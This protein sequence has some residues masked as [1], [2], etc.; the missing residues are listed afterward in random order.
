M[1]HTN[2]SAVIAGLVFIALSVVFLLESADVWEVRGLVALSSIGLGVA[3]LA[4][5][6]WRADRR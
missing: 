3:V 4:G 5:A 2:P 1:N 6:L